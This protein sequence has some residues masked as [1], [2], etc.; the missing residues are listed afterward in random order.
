[1]MSETGKTVSLPELVEQHYVPLYRYA[2]RLSGSTADAEDLTQQ[3]FL[4]AQKKL[5]QLRSDEGARSWL[6]TILRNLFL[7]SVRGAA[8][9][10]VISLDQVAEPVEA[11]PA[12]EIDSEQLQAVLNEI[13]EEFRLPLLMF[14]FEELSYREIAEQLDIPIGTVMSRLARGRTWLRRRLAAGAPV[15]SMREQ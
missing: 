9:R 2:C 12:T 6:F 4:T 7:R 11:A 15:S 5:D 1:M 13:A 10:G 14:Y 3:T 8:G